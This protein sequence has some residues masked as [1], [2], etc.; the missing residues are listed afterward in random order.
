M[1]EEDNKA[2]LEEIAVN[3]S[4]IADKLTEIATALDKIVIAISVHK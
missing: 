3:S 1:F 2:S 4:K